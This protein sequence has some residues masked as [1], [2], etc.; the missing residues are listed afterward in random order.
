MDASIPAPIT[1]EVWSVIKFLNAQGIAPIE[2][3][4]QLCRSM[5][6]QMLNRLTADR[7]SKRD[8]KYVTGDGEFEQSKVYLVSNYHKEIMD[9]GDMN[10]RANLLREQSNDNVRTDKG[11]VP[12]TVTDE[13]DINKRMRKKQETC[14][15]IMMTAPGR[16]GRNE[17]RHTG[18]ENS[19][20]SSVNPAGRINMGQQLQKGSREEEEN[21]IKV[22]ILQELEG[23]N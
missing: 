23:M 8:R 6:K 18:D 14:T 21:K 11:N 9:Q 10:D 4:R 5:G 2:I 3:D 13:D 15:K 20:K 1:C 17:E 12:A 7:N 19:K 16:Q 22:K